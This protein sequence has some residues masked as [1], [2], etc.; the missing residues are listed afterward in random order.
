MSLLQRGTFSWPLVIT[1]TLVHFVSTLCSV[2]CVDIS[3][4]H[5]SGPL[6][7]Y[8]DPL[9][10]SSFLVF[11]WL[12]MVSATHLPSC[13][14]VGRFLENG[15]YGLSAVGLSFLL[16]QSLHLTARLSSSRSFALLLISST[17]T[18]QCLLPGPVLF[19]KRHLTVFGDT[20][21]FH[22]RAHD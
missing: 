7:P 22:K 10:C 18:D 9:P 21:D 8:C 12:Y 2:W 4:S 13:S 16:S 1:L 17:H 6:P 5:T 11:T 3:A 19:P 15:G 14:S 20:I